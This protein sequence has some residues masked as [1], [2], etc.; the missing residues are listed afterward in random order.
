MGI[1][2]K[3]PVEQPRYSWYFL[4]V[5][6]HKEQEVRMETEE[7]IKEFIERVGL[8]EDEGIADFNSMSLDEW[9][10]QCVRLALGI[11]EWANRLELRILSIEYRLDRLEK[12]EGH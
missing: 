3:A 11:K 8:N 4:L 9:Q 7:K 6:G 12:R 1:L 2:I 10:D 5:A